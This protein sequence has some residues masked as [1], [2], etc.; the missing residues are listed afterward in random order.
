MFFVDDSCK[1]RCLK[2][3]THTLL[4]THTH[5]Q[6]ARSSRQQQPQQSVQPQQCKLPGVLRRVQWIH[7][8]VGAEQPRQ[9]VQPQQRRV[10]LV[11]QRRSSL[12]ATPSVRVKRFCFPRNRLL[13]ALGFYSAKKSLLLMGVARVKRSKFFLCSCARSTFCFSILAMN[14]F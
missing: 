12:R 11:A 3:N 4:H 6:N 1:S 9:S 7:Y 14:L 5:T 13:P 2:G 8:V 10:Q